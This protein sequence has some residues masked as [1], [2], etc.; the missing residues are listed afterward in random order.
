[1]VWKPRCILGW[2]GVG[3]W[4]QKEEAS[5]TEMTQNGKSAMRLCMIGGVGESDRAPHQG[6][7]QGEHSQLLCRSEQ[8][9]V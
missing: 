6:H 5:K 9:V 7:I 3:E 2:D 4:E 1:M 8:D